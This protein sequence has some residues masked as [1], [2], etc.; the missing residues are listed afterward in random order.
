MTASE[1]LT[2][3]SFQAIGTNVAIAVTEPGAADLAAAMLRSRLSTLD[4]ACSRFRPDSEISMLQRSAGS[5][6]PVSDVLFDAVAVACDV[7]R[8]TGGAVDPTVGRALEV[9]GYDRD[10]RLLSPEE[11][12]GGREEPSPAP[13]WW[14]IGLDA[15]RRT[16]CVPHGVHLD[17]GSSAKAWA[18]DRAAR[19][20]AA[21]LET[22]VLVS[23][24][25]DVS[26]AGPPPRG[27]WRIGIAVESSTPVDEVDQVVSLTRGGLASSS[28]GVRS[29]GPGRTR[30]HIV[31]PRSG[32]SSSTYWT[33]V[34]ASAPTCVEANAMTTA[35][36]VWGSSAVARLAGF[37][38]PLRLVR[39]D[40]AVVTLNG[41]P[42][43]R[44]A[45]Q[46]RLERS[47]VAG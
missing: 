41:W 24:G 27:G 4:E 2:L 6:M 18:A 37:G 20:I 15:E 32:E 30:H 34:S 42:A 40:G 31:D 9:L 38:H 7:A 22:G 47:G 13:G 21:R 29:W 44:E 36:I 17:V 8:L 19:H 46:G 11:V 35:A 45:A 3:R 28:P 10:Y 26:V 23:L 1:S 12:E 14:C 5:A 33:L 39:H 16:I 43:D 25:G